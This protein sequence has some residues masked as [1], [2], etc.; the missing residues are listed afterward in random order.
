MADTGKHNQ[1]RH[2]KNNKTNHKDYFKR[3]RLMIGGLNKAGEFITA[4]ATVFLAIITGLLALIAYWQWGEMVAESRPVVGFDEADISIT[5]PF[6]FSDDGATI[7]FN[8]PVKNVGK[9]VA[10]GIETFSR[11]QVGYLVPEGKVYSLRDIQDSLE[12]WVGCT[13]ALAKTFNGPGSLIL[14]NGHLDISRD[15][16]A[17][18]SAFTTDPTTKM[19]NPFL[20]FCVIYRDDGGHSHGTGAILQFSADSNATDFPLTTR[21]EIK[22]KLKIFGAGASVF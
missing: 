19:V 22:G 10:L 7:S 1:P 6:N 21:G 5:K 9:S 18:R 15:E 3:F 17:T 11:L 16:K 13:P 20:S 4:I 12:R 8:V 14:P 2:T